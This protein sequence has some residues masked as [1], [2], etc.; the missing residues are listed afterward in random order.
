MLLLSELVMFET[1][2]KI[3]RDDYAAET[4]YEL[5]YKSLIMSRMPKASECCKDPHFPF[6]LMF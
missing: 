1:V 6:S 2:F 3:L 5:Y 4:A